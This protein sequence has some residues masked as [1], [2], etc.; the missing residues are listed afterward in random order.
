MAFF[1]NRSVRREWVARLPEEADSVFR[2]A[3]MQLETGYGMLSV[4]LNEALGLSQEGDLCAA[5]AEAGIC[6][7]LYENLAGLLLRGLQAL[8]SHTR[9]YGTQP[10]VVPLEPGYFRGE[11][12][13]RS[14]TWNSLLHIVLFGSRSR[15]FHKVQTLREIVAELAIE[16]RGNARELSEGTAIDPAGSWES[17]EAMHDDL[18]TCLR[19]TVVMLKCFLRALPADELKA[20]RSRF[21]PAMAAQHQATDLA[22]RDALF[23]GTP[24]RRISSKMR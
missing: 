14:S 5:R 23:G 21:D 12:S 13:R 9:H 15:W 10:A 22:N 2:A 18:N 11:A 16:F 20:F 19:E 8:E 1:S 7:T 6:G 24:G 4:T 17:L 3:E